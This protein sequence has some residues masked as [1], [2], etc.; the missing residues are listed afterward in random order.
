[1]G[2]AFLSARLAT[3]RTPTADAEVCLTCWGCEGQRSGGSAL[4][5][6]PPPLLSQPAT[7]PAPPAGVPRCPSAPPVPAGCSCTRASV[8]TR[9]GRGSTPR[10]AP[11]TVRTPPHP[12]DLW[13]CPLLSLALPA[14]R[15]P[16]V[17]PG[18]RGA[19][20]LR[21]PP[22]WEGGGR[23]AAPGG[24][25]PP[26]RRLH[27]CLSCTQTPG[28]H[29][30]LQRSVPALVFNQFIRISTIAKLSSHH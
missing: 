27:G 1:M 9:V 3:T 11:A 12:Q 13:I 24:A 25:A 18:L 28:P 2:S 10:T 29:A 6:P 20:G 30:D 8:W 15:L 5:S 7:A 17:L 14:S 22:L 4:P 23:A 19:A 26:A 21:L 16:P